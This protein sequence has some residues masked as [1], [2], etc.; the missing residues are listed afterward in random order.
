VTLL[1][2]RRGGAH[3]GRPRDFG[4]EHVDDARQRFVLGVGALAR[5]GAR[6]VA[7]DV[8]EKKAPDI[9]LLERP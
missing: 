5:I 9:R 2:P 3:V 6:G 8:D 1:R 4:F 7:R